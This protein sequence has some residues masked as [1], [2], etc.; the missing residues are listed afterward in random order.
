M[1]L[2]VLRAEAIAD[3][4]ATKAVIHRSETVTSQVIDLRQPGT[5]STLI[6]PGDRIEFTS[7]AGAM[8]VASAGYFYIS[9]DVASA[10]QKEFTPGMT[11]LQ[12]IVASGG[13]KGNSKKATIRRKRDTGI[14]SVSEFNLRKIKDGKSA[15][16]SLAPG[17][18]IEIG[19]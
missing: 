12:A 14:L 18:M 7:D 3:S 10:G 8:P 19:D 16:P 9:G 6:Y 1:P 11:L 2:Y 5:D 17:D 15:D 13:S 4:R